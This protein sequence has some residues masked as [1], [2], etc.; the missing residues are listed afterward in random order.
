MQLDL[1]KHVSGKS[2]AIQLPPR[3]QLRLS[4][5]QQQADPTG[6]T[7]QTCRAPPTATTPGDTLQML[8]R[9]D[10]DCPYLHQAIHSPITDSSV[11]QGDGHVTQHTPPTCR[12]WQAGAHSP[13]KRVKSGK[14]AS[15]M[16]G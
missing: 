11:E 9:G 5:S 10:E 13:C 12:T 3:P 6:A 1:R 14:N 7:D 8:W 4:A 16:A 15:K 2:R